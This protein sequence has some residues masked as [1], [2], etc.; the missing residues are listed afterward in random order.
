MTDPATDPSRLI[1]EAEPTRASESAPAPADYRALAEFRHG[2]R[3]FLAFSEEAARGHGLTPQ[4]HQAILAIKGSGNEAMTISELAERLMV[5]HNSA[6]ELVNRLEKAGLVARGEWPA[7]RRRVIV[8]LEPAAEEAL[9]ALSSAH[10]A[11]LKR[12]RPLLLDVL[13]RIEG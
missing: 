8:R 12:M 10:L 13:A 7:D 11:E 4:Q 6:V 5:R 9:A 3:R 1:T 2:L